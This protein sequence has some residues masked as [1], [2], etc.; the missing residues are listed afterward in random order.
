MLNETIINQAYDQLKDTRQKLFD[1]HNRLI[2]TQRL[3]TKKKTELIASGV[4]DGK[5]EEA[6]KA[7]IASMA[8]METGAVFGAETKLDT[9]QLMNEFANYEVNR[10]NTLIKWLSL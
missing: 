6:R 2:E 4:I 9:A 5:N 8:E 10:I 3:L 1:A 7:Q